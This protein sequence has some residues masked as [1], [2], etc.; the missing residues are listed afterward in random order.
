MS[1]AV[2]VADTVAQRAAPPDVAVKEPVAPEAERTVSA[3]A[4]L[5]LP[6][7]IL[8]SSWRLVSPEKLADHVLPSV[9]PTQTNK[10]VEPVG[11]TEGATILEALLL[12]AVLPN[13]SPAETPV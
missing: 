12:F 13:T 9:A 6:P 10:S 8:E 3:M 1:P 11:D 5:K 2:N 4:M 7:P